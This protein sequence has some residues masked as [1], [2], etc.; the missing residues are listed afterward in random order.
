[1]NRKIHQH[2]YVIKRD[3]SKEL[4]DVLKIKKSIEFAT[5][6]QGVN[7]LQLESSIDQV[8]KNGVKTSDIQDNVIRHALQQATAQNPKWVNV[9]G[10]ALAMQMWANFSLRG[11]SFYEVVQYN[12]KKG[13][14]TEEL[15]DFYSKE[16]IDQLGECIDHQ[17]DLEH[18]YS[19]LFTVQK[20]YLGK[21][22]LNQHMHMVSA[23]RF[24]QLEP[25]ET[26]LEFVKN[27]YEVL[28]KRKISLATP[29]M[30]N[31]RRGGNVA[32]CFIIAIDDDLDS[33]FNNVHRIA[34]ISKNGGG[35]GIYLGNIR[36][37]GSSVSNYSN[38]AGTIVQWVKIINDTLVAVN[39]G[40]RR[41]G[42]GTV[43]L[44]IWH[45]DILD[46]LD[47]Q[48]EHGDQRMKAYD[49][50]PQV[51]VPDLFMERDVEQKPWITFCP[52]EV[53]T[54]L[55]IDIAKLYGDEFKKA[56]LQI[57]EAFEQG[58]LKIARKHD[59][60]RTITKTIMRTQLETG[61][62]Y[63]TFIDTINAVNPNSHNGLITNV[64]LCTESFSNVVPDMYGHVCNLCSINL[65][66]IDN[67]DDLATVSR[68]SARMLDHG[69]DLTNNPDEITKNHNTRYRTIGIGQM[70]LHD[71]LAKNNTNFSNLDLIREISECIEYNAVLESI[72]LAKENIPF[73]AFS[74]S[75]WDTGE[76]TEMF[77][78]H[79]NGKYNWDKAQQLIDKYGIRN[80]QL[81]S[82]APTT[83][84]SIYQD[85]SAS[86]LPV[87]SAFF[88]E[89]NSNGTLVVAAKFL[90]EN[91]LGYGKTFSK[92]RATE[93]IDF[94]SEIQKFVDTGVSMELLFDQND[95]TFSAKT[96]YESIHYAH[97]KGIKAIYYIRSI[98][99]NA[100]LE[101]KEEACVACS[102]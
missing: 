4:F 72:E 5:E 96:L 29:F 78:S 84:T 70:G 36:A 1:M 86:V 49:V 102:G 28:S 20:K 6:G 59:N 90:D 74:G 101:T 77:K 17:R 97:Q 16:D 44:P 69:I 98:K 23:M 10:R 12:I 99:R 33:I 26:R 8:I 38:A 62:P 56:Y 81:T 7:A 53:K 54:V 60:A 45:N 73:Q 51:V 24:G 55:G 39:Q 14:Y 34:K 43:A 80:S 92:H 11:K 89:D 48:T 2:T 18:S 30:A 27:L 100:T 85:C 41:A 15:N 46:F 79:S 76:M 25:K 50:F 22:E 94:V 91:P 65:S 64:N 71:Y 83:S 67:F 57:E 47:M 13:E 88:A 42:A 37:K 21:Y 82:P 93:I 58:K 40:G 66:N 9:A 32:S 31:L 95:P 61:L 87:Y 52:F 68:L 19:S 75:K 35:I 3:G 63:I